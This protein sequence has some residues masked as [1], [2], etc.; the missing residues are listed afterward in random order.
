MKRTIFMVALVFTFLMS[1]CP[2]T[3]AQALNNVTMLKQFLD[4]QP[5]NG[6]ANPIK[7]TMAANDLIIEDIAKTIKSAGKY[8]NLELTGNF[9]TYIS[10]FSE[11]YALV[12]ITIPSS[13]TYIGYHAFEKCYNLTSV[14]IP[15][16]VTEIGDSAFQYCFS[17]T[18]VTF[19]TGSNITNNNFGE[20]AFLINY[21]SV[22]NLK[23]AYSTGKAGTYT[24][25]KDGDTWTKK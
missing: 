2:K 5:V 19:A 16:S 17:L 14:T 3:A 25:P 15:S 11:C 4:N 12:N 8:V 13:V 24:R 21:N 7:V 22:N 20:R 6:P 23:T 9:L 1:A 18:S 10:Y